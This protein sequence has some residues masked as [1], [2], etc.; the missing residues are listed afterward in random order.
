VPA[1]CLLVAGAIV[2]SL[3]GPEFTLA[4]T[5]S[6]QKTRWEERYRVDGNTLVLVEAS[7]EGTGAGMEP[8]PDARFRD[9]RW[10]WQPGTRL[11]EVTLRRSPWSADYALCSDGRCRPLGELVGPTAPD[12]TVTFA[13]CAGAP[14]R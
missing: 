8:A 5:H 1:A 2:A 14:E 12:A 4:W 13:P 10:V 11:A 7:V 9:G 6:V 3:P